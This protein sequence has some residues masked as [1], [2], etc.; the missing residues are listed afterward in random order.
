MC[1]EPLCE[2]HYVGWRKKQ[3]ESVNSAKMSKT[4][5]YPFAFKDKS[6]RQFLKLKDEKKLCCRHTVNSV[7]LY[8]T[9]DNSETHKRKYVD[10]I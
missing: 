1:N 4:K 10:A 6:R 3:Q 8:L 5:F 9:C 7:E 2:G